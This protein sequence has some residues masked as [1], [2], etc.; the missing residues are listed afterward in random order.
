M[1]QMRARVREVRDTNLLVYDECTQQDVLVHTC[2][3]PCYCYGDRLCIRY[4]GVMTQSIPP[5]IT[6]TCIRRL[7]NCRR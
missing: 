6:A 7:R 3:A 4:N 5:Q 2:K 1:R